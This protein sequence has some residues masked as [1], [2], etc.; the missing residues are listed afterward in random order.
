MFGG[1]PGPVGRKLRAAS[2]SMPLAVAYN[3]GG[4]QAEESISNPLANELRNSIEVP[5]VSNATRIMIVGAMPPSP[6]MPSAKAPTPVR[7]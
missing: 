5:V 4:L 3:W 7:T 1:A 2:G 6:K